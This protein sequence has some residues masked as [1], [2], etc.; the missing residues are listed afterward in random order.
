MRE[1]RYIKPK[2]EES[3]A[4]HDVFDVGAQKPV[5]IPKEGSVQLF[6]TTRSVA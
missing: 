6:E 1:G 3:D 4:M 5:Y 2:H